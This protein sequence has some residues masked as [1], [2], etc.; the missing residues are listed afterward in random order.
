MN[1][2]EIIEALKN[3]HECKHPGCQS[4]NETDSISFVKKKIEEYEKRLETL[5]AI[6]ADTLVRIDLQ[7]ETLNKGNLT[8]AIIKAGFGSGLNHFG[9]AFVDAY[10]PQII[11]ADTACLEFAK[12]KLSELEAEAATK[13][14][15]E[16]AVTSA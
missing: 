15:T 8:T 4:N 12:S 14:E 7:I 6:K 13:T 10:I 2:L 9:R 11:A 16:A 5:R 1:I 3:E